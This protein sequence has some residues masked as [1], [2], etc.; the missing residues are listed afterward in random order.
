V[1]VKAGQ[2]VLGTGKGKNKKEA[3]QEAA[4]DGLCHWQRNHQE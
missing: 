3:E 4:K 1:E 2:K